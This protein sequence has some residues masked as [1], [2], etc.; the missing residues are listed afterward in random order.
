MLNGLTITE[1]A[2]RLLSRVRR[3]DVFNGG[4]ALGFYLTLAI[5]PAMIFLM[6][7]IPY[8]PIPHVDQAIMDLLRQALPNRAARLFSTVVNEVASEPRGGLLSLGIVGA[9]WAA[10]TGM[11]AV[12]QQLNIAF[13]VRERRRFLR[14]RTTAILLTL[15]FGT[16]VLASFSLVVLGGVVQDW[17]GKRFGFGS[18]LLGFFVVFRWFIIVLSLMFGLALV[19]H[20]APNRRRPFHFVSV[21]TVAATALM[22]VASVALSLYTSHFGNYNAV[23]GSIGAM[24]VLMLSLYVSGLVV[25]VGAEIDAVLERAPAPARAGERP[26]LAGKHQSAAG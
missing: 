2:R 23:Y 21:G 14:A 3:N 10:S 5:F 12:M 11:Y 18:L 24:I 1:F 6:A 9:V 8:L 16:L 19:Y 15:L 25:L 7:L 20:F 4:A 17:I 22:I 26:R 13:G